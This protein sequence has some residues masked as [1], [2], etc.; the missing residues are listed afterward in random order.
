MGSPLPPRGVN[1]RTLFIG[2]S[3]PPGGWNR[4]VATTPNGERLEEPYWP[5][6]DR[7]LLT[8]HHLAIDCAHR[9]DLDAPMVGPMVGK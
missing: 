8:G 7:R 2:L 9:H 3:Q 6:H 5:D 4:D 1:T